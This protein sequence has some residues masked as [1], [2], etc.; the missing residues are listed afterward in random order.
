[1]PIHIVQRGDTV[2]AIANRYG[3]SP[4][5]LITDNGL[6][7]QP[8]LVEGQALLVLIP[9]TIHT[10]RANET[11][12]SI[13]A[14]Y[15]TTQM[16]FLQKN[17]NLIANPRLSPG[18]QLVVRFREEPERTVYINGYAYPFINQA[19]Y[20]RTLP[21]LSDVTLFGYGFTETGD[22]IPIDDTE[23]ISLAYQYQ[24]APILLLSSI[25]EDGNF[26]GERASLLFRNPQLQETVLRNILAVM[27]EK[28]YL[29][30]DIDFEFIN[31][32]D[33]TAFV[34]FVR[35]ATEL[36]HQNGY[37][38]NVDLAPKTSSD[39]KGLLYEAHDYAALGA[40]ADTVLIMTYEWGYTYGPPLAVSPIPNVRQVVAYAV[41]QIDPA[42]IMLGIPN[43]GYDWRLPYERG[44]TRATAI[45]NEDAV[46]IAAENGAIIQFDETAQAPFFEYF[47]RDR[48]K[49]IVWF[50]DVRS[51]E[52]KFNLISEFGL[53]G[54]GYWNIMRP[55]AQ[56]WALLSQR[57]QIDKMND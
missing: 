17:P 29:G 35:N 15:G 45:G 48:S 20:R 54:G 28:G 31:P 37:R 22:L 4:Q 23:L 8:Y 12:S 40:I 42:K 30:L 5:R 16:E 9:E 46:R 51:I 33:S 44:V 32:E 43:Y 47:A 21:Y 6:S 57:F 36:M 41:T 14:L 2:Y 34:D 13:A 38:V 24:S 53:R 55:F 39:Q 7:S 52:A 11:L 1:M 27:K 25:T 18:Q 56:N 10:V 50:E 49:H 3:V 19:L 26:S